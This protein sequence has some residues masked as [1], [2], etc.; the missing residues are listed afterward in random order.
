VYS[1]QYFDNKWHAFVVILE[2]KFMKPMIL[3]TGIL[4]LVSVWAQSQT[5][6]SKLKQAT[7]SKS[8]ATT[9]SIN[10]PATISSNT[11]SLTS[12][13]NYSAKANTSSLLMQNRYTITDPIL[14]TL[15]ARAEGANVRLN[16]SGI[17]GMPKRAY[18]FANGHI[19][20]RT[21]GAVT[22]GTQTGSGAVATG[23]SLATFGSIGASMNVNGKSNYAGIN[24]WGN[25][26]N[27]NITG[28]DSSVRIPSSS[29]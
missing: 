7:A 6:K 23:T 21:T 8:P 10:Q 29:Q 22:S 3:C 19:T 28:R 26:R 15:D 12:A 17:V 27:M 2:K 14:T 25:A 13:A 20:L 11:V 5:K 1:L 24:M 9:N 4:L 18:G 16:N